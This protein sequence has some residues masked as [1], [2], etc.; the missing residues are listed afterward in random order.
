[1]RALS[2]QELLDVW[3]RGLARAP[4]QRALELLAA[5]CPE[6]P[7]DSLAALTIGQRDAKLLT[8]REWAFGARMTGVAVCPA[9]GRRL[10]LPFNAAEMR[11]GSQAPESEVSVSAAG[12][13]VR[14]RPPNGEDAIAAAGLADIGGGRRLILQRCLLSAHY[15]GEPVDGDRLPPEVV[16][17][18]A[19]RMSEADPLA[20]IQ[21]VVACP[22]CRHG[23]RAVFDVVS[24]FWTEIEAWA[25][26]MLSDVHTLAAAYGWREPD[27][28][29]LSPVRRQFYLEMVGA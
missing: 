3:E 20:D 18:V 22:Y 6:T 21:V 17:T 4:A 9:C 14:F 15:N 23:W 26:R 24:F 27:I 29:T 16:E 11:S 5:A 12:Y 10:E 8:L 2:A 1:M 13:D 25:W 28:L 19:Q 7:P